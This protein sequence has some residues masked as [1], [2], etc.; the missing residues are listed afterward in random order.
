MMTWWD[1]QQNID[2][3]KNAD[4]S[5]GFTRI[6]YVYDDEAEVDYQLDGTDDLVFRVGAHH[7]FGA[8]QKDRGVYL[9][10]TNFSNIG[11][12]T[13]NFGYEDVMGFALIG[14]IGNFKINVV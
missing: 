6:G 13:I 12:E 14:K 4:C 1:F 11:N 7:R 9:T 2:A 5:I 10:L 8:E 3:G